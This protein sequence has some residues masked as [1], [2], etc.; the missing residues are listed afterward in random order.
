MSNDS[1]E[2]DAEKILNNAE[3]L[4]EL[5][6]LAKKQSAL[7]DLS[8]CDPPLFG[9]TLHSSILARID[10][11]VPSQYAG[12]AIGT[13]DLELRKSLSQRIQEFTGFSLPANKIV[14]T[15]GVS[16]G[17]ELVFDAVFHFQPG[18]VAIPE[19]TYLPLVF[20]ANRFAKVWF[21]SCREEIDWNPDIDAL[22][23]S[24]ESQPDTR[25]IILINPNSPT[26]AVYSEQTLKELVNLAGQYNL[27]MI[28]NEIYDA[29]SFDRFYSLLQCAAE[30]PVIYLNGF[31][32]VFRL[33][34][35][36]IGYLGWYDPKNASTDVW[37]RIISLS[38][39]RLGTSPL[40]QEIAKIALQEPLEGL[41]AF[42]QTVRERMEFLAQQLESIEGITVVPAK[43]ST[44]IFPKLEIDD[45]LV[46]K[47]L[48]REY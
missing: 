2:S 24:L 34:G 11:L 38:R 7:L 1:I 33:P 9:H 37:E 36:R 5:G 18:S 8:M 23:R 10:N 25:A 3:I 44:Y 21:Y 19:P 4:S 6:E 45:K 48:L 27:T 43:G 17:F 14:L 41:K 47:H 26:G 13:G 42:V 30:V 15:N 12:Y 35:Y 40:S 16:E 28:T 39:M 22:S 20:Q 46:A 31:S 29:I 32:K